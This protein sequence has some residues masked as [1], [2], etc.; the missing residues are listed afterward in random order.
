MYFTT[1]SIN[2]LPTSVNVGRLRHMVSLPVGYQAQAGQIRYD[3]G[4]VL[5]MGSD[6]YAIYQSLPKLIGLGLT[7]RTY[8]P[9]II[10]SMSLVARVGITQKSLVI[11]LGFLFLYHHT[12]SDSSA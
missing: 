8:F 7:S 11:R 10:S 4:E 3:E 2:Q 5:Q 12:V 1:W 6:S 9:E